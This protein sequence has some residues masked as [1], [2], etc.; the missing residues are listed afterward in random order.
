MNLSWMVTLSPR[1]VSASLRCK[2]KSEVIEHTD[3]LK[4]WFWNTAGRLKHLGLAF[5]IFLSF[6]EKLICFFSIITWHMLLKAQQIILLNKC[7]SWTLYRSDEIQFIMYLCNFSGLFSILLCRL[8]QTTKSPTSFL[9]FLLGDN[10]TENRLSAFQLVCIFLLLGPLCR[11]QIYES[12]K[13]ILFLMAEQLVFYFYFLWMCL[14]KFAAVI[15][16]Y[17]RS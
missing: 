3:L 15:T 1:T 7:M 12:F 5:H 9:F 4:L 17:F 14:C 2:W 11:P 10:W 13:Y 8:L 6:F 16:N